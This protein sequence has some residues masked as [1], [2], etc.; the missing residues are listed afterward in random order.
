MYIK[1]NKERLITAGRN[2]ID[3]KR[4][5]RI[6]IKTWKPKWEEKQLQRY[7]K[8]QTGEISHMKIWTMLQKRNLIREFEFLVIT[9]RNNAIRTNYVEAKINHIIREWSKRAQKECKTRHNWYIYIFSSFI[10]C[11]QHGYPW[12]SLVTPPYSSSLPAGPQGYKPY[13]HRAAV[14][15]FELAALLLL[16][17]V[18][19]SIGVHHL[20]TLPNSPAVS[21]MSGY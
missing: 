4:T 7:Y 19:G 1:K 6:T 16:G 11:H 9:A 8:W 14:C 18:K 10:L 2:N 15:R 3:N 12:P 17:H 13:P 21:C 20:W 5:N